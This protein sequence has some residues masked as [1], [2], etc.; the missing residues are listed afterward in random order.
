MRSRRQAESL[1]WLNGM[2]LKNGLKSSTVRCQRDDDW[3]GPPSKYKSYDEFVL[4]EGESMDMSYEPKIQEVVAPKSTPGD[5][6]N[7]PSCAKIN[8]PM[9]PDDQKKECVIVHL[10]HRPKCKSVADTV[11]FLNQVMRDEGF[12]D[13][14]T[15]KA[16][17]SYRSEQRTVVLEML[18]IELQ[19]KICWLNA[20]PWSNFGIIRISGP[21]WSI[22]PQYNSWAVFKAQGDRCLIRVY[23]RNPPNWYKDHDL[24]QFFNSAMWRFGLARKD[25]LGVLRF[26]FLTPNVG[27]FEVP[28][29]AMQE[30]LLYLNGIGGCT[31]DPNYRFHLEPH[32]SYVG[33][34]PKYKWFSEFLKNFEIQNPSP[35]RSAYQFERSGRDATRDPSCDDQA[36]GSPFS[37]SN[38]RSYPNLHL[39]I[40]ASPNRS[41]DHHVPTFVESDRG[42]KQ[43]FDEAAHRSLGS[44]SRNQLASQVKDENAQLRKQVADLQKSNGD[45]KKSILDSTHAANGF[46]SLLSEVK[47]KLA[48]TT[49]QLDAVHQSWQE[50]TQVI[51]SKDAELAELQG[52][53]DKLSECADQSDKELAAKSQALL[54]ETTKRQKAEKIVGLILTGNRKK[55]ARINSAMAALNRPKST[56][57]EEISHV[58]G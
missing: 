34:A 36:Q 14:Q 40:A 37:K 31:E 24:V 38:D 15:T 54:I 45:L 8:P 2:I 32:Q 21:D 22:K 56:K 50:Q 35:S 27:S 41:K 11:D 28:N 10:V 5:G 20:I 44:N 55:Q 53:V 29:G 42:R 26:Q 30:K 48:T 46:R 19:K 12:V 33:P 58:G 3:T 9:V 52:R 23:L 17:V 6:R 18:N 7:E 4:A 47:E 43:L 1:C 39:P 57:K 49:W 13:Q 25:E 51:A 16:I